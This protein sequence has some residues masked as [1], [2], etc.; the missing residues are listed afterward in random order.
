MRLALR[1]RI[2][3][4]ETYRLHGV[5]QLG[6]PLRMVVIAT[7]AWVKGCRA[8]QIRSGAHEFAQLVA[9]SEHG[10]ELA[11]CGI[12]LENGV[13][14]VIVGR[15]AFDDADKVVESGVRVEGARQC[16]GDV[17]DM[18]GVHAVCIE[19]GERR[20]CLIQPLESDMDEVTGAERICRRRIHTSNIR[21]PLRG[22]ADAS[23]PSNYLSACDVI[24]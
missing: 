22:V 14:A 10:D 8:N 5:K 9:G 13:Q 2:P 3:Q 19:R 6:H 15:Q 16:V 1:L 11:S 12:I 18:L 24:E 20:S 23:V 17:A 21:P 4:L 7:M